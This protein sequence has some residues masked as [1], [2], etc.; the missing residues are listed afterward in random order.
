MS[1]GRAYTPP[2]TLAGERSVAQA[3]H[4]L[5][6]WPLSGPVELEA[7]FVWRYPKSWPADKVA[8]AR[9]GKIAHLHVPDVDNLLKLV[10]DGLNGIAYV[11][12]SQ[13]VKVTGWKRYGEESQTLVTV[14]DLGVECLAV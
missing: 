11:D 12:D 9:D 1:R 5:F 10:Q 7:T 6:G 8:A 3:A 13:I 2:R 14:K 4:P